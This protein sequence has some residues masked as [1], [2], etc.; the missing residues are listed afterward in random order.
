MTAVLGDFQGETCRKRRVVKSGIGAF[1]PGQAEPAL[2]HRR[3]PGQRSSVEWWYGGR[4]HGFGPGCRVDIVLHGISVPA[5]V[6]DK[7]EL[8]VV[9]LLRPQLFQR[10][11]RLLLETRLQV[12]L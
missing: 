3:Q 8:R 11:F 4:H 6:V 10:G 2:G 12:Q 5:A 7:W 9:D 1:A